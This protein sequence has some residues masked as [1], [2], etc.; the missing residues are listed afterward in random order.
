M[1]IKIA[2]LISALSFFFPVFLG[3]CDVILLDQ[4]L[5][6]HHELFARIDRQLLAQALRQVAPD[7]LVKIVDSAFVFLAHAA[8]A[9]LVACGLAV[10]LGIALRR[11]LLLIL[12]LAVLVL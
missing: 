7:V 4:V 9:G 10:V 11:A 8:G 5:I 3:Q 6:L 2:L 1:I 12:V